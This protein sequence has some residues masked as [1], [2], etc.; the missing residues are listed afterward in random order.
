MT[1]RCLWGGLE[2][3]L[4]GADDSLIEINER[5]EVLKAEGT[6]PYVRK[7]DGKES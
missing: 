6:G 5:I 4:R 3:C 1:S 2:G 7:L